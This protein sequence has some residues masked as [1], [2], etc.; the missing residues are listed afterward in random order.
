MVQLSEKLK[1]EIIIKKEM[2]LTAT[3]FAIEMNINIKT[4]LKWISRY[5]NQNTI[6]NLPKKGRNKKITD[7]FDKNIIECV[8]ECISKPTLSNINDKLQKRNIHVSIS[9]L[10]NRL[11]DK[12]ILNQLEIKTLETKLLNL[13]LNK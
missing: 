1:Y 6:E 4:V 5:K 3:Q 9:S 13:K 10:R 8:F 11:K 2:G 7:E 12:N